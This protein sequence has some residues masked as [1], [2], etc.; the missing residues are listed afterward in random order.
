MMVL[1][2]DPR[3]IR[4]YC[5]ESLSKF[6]EIA[7]KRLVNDGKSRPTTVEAWL[8]MDNNSTENSFSSSQGLSGLQDRRVLSCRGAFKSRIRG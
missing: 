2:I 6:G 4:N 1:I 7:E 8:N 5:P 3:L